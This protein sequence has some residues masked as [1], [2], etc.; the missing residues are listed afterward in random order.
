MTRAIAL[1]ML[2]GLFATWFVGAALADQTS[3]ANGN[4]VHT[5]LAPVV[6]HRAFPPYTGVHVYSKGGGNNGGRRGR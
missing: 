5:R 2:T 4:V 1:L 6:M 3:N